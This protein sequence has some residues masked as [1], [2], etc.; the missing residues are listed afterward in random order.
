VS[1]LAG[2]RLW[3]DDTSETSVECEFSTGFEIDSSVPIAVTSGVGGHVGVHQVAFHQLAPDRAGSARRAEALG[4]RH[5]LLFTGEPAGDGWEIAHRSGNVVLAERTGGTDVVGVGCIASVWTGSDDALR[6]RLFAGLA[7]KRGA[8]ALL[9]PHTFVALETVERQALTERAA[10]LA[11]CSVESAEVHEHPREPGAHEADVEIPAPV[12]LVIRV[13]AFPTWRVLVDGQEAKTTTVAPGFP[14]VRIPAGKH[15]VEAV[16]SL[17]P[18]YLRGIG[19]GLLG[20]VICSLSTVRLRARRA[21]RST[22]TPSAPG[23]PR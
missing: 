3:Y 16:V 14:S 12:D 21:A 9:D 5:L 1:S 19:A 15:H 10:D 13:A 6:E 20:A 17:F 4:V 8:R 18:G 22:P 7:T 23:S 11:G 2:G